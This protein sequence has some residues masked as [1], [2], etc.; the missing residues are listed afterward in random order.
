M[1]AQASKL[2]AFISPF[3]KVQAPNKGSR[4]LFFFPPAKLKF[5]RSNF[6]VKN[7]APKLISCSFKLYLG[8]VCLLVPFMALVMLFY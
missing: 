8:C 4:F 6:K 2:K 5:H 7:Q 1:H 3:I